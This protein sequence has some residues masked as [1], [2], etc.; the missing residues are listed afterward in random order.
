VNAAPAHIV[1]EVV[2]YEL[3]KAFAAH[4]WIIPA[5]L[6]AFPLLPFVI[7]LLRPLTSE[8]FP[9]LT[10]ELLEGIYARVFLAYSLRLGI[11]FAA[12][13]VFAQLYRREVQEKTL[14]T[15]LLL[16]VDGSQII[17]GKYFAGCVLVGSA[18]TISSILGYLLL[19]L[20]EGPSASLAHLVTGG[21][22]AHL[23]AYAALA[24]LGTVAYG[25]L[26]LFVGTLRRSPVLPVLG[27]FLLESVDALLPG[28]LQQLSIIHTL[29]GFLPVEPVGSRTPGDA[30]WTEMAVIL[31][32]TA[33]LLILSIRAMRRAEIS[34]SD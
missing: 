33:G 20:P 34:Y 13:S 12:V 14:H 11:F 28:P 31:G 25:A 24:L 8:R 18:F 27:I 21:G 19:F 5:V 16:P 1:S 23:A 30:G 7:L 32:L 4:R 2:S 9:P 6:A 3:R 17:V 29:G 15:Y 22:L 26:F 10:P